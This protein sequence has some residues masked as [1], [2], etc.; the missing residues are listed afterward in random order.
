MKYEIEILREGGVKKS[1]AIYGWNLNLAIWLE[2]K[3]G[4]IMSRASGVE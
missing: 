1:S 3:F 4:K 2:S